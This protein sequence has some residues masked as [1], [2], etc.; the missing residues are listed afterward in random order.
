MP[1]RHASGSRSLIARLL[2]RPVFRHHFNGG[3]FLEIV[4]D[5]ARH[6]VVMRSGEDIIHEDEIAGKHWTRAH[7]RYYTPWTLEVFTGRGRRV[8]RHE[9]DL[10]GRS[11]RVNI[12]SRSLGDTL[13]W[14]PQVQA[15]ARAHPD[16]RVHVSQFWPD[17]FDREA[18]PELV[19]IDPDAVLEDCY[20]TYDVGYYFEHADWHH[21]EDPRRQPLGKIAAD[22]LGI[23]YQEVRP[24][25]P[26]LPAPPATCGRPVICIGTASTAECKHWL[27]PDGWQTLV[28]HLG[29]QGFDVVAIQKEPCSL[30]GIVDETGDRP[31][32]ERMAR[33][34]GCRL[35][36][37]L[38]SGLSWLAWALGTPVVLI[39]GFS[40]SWAEFTGNCERVINT[41]VCHGCWNDS[42]HAFDRR[43]WNWCPRLGDSDR[44]FECSRAITP[45]MVIAAVERMLSRSGNQ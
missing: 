11:V 36:V 6:R 44:R 35:F 23:P 27:H 30:S 9:F 39:S 31:I 29:E 14:L 17:L 22:I 20:A 18:Y 25:L 45:E 26:T 28:D 1:E 15:F 24:R 12:D 3:P 16:A 2:R 33:L 34:A 7:R 4:S 19:F 38:G 43:D 42:A 37:G 40:E 10:S 41:A 21:P 5:A 32:G 8:F 13:A